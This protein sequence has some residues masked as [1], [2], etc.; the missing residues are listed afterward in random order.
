M[1][2]IRPLVQAA[3]QHGDDVRQVRAVGV[4]ELLPDQGQADLYYA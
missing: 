3:H 2:A 1:S 4:G